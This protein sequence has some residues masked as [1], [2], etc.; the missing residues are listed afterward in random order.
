MK[1]TNELIIIRF[2]DKYRGT[3]IAAHILQKEIPDFAW[4]IYHRS[5]T[6]AT[7]DR[8]WRSLRV[9]S[10]N[11]LELNGYSII[12]DYTYIGKEKKFIIRR[13]SEVHR[14]SQGKSEQAGNNNPVVGSE[15]SHRTTAGTL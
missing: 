11:L 4:D 6:P 7:I 10:N 14:N 15:E 13:I 3:T 1:L 2:L 5:V 8:A 12:E 9:V